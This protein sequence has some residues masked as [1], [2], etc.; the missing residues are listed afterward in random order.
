M[1]HEYLTQLLR[2]QDLS[3]AQLRELREQRDLVERC[4]R[5]SYGSDPR[6]YYA[7]SY[8]KDTM[9]AAA[10]DLDVVV[11]FPPS[12]RRTLAELFWGVNRRLTDCGF[13]VVPRTV[14]LRLPYSGPFHVDVV[15]GKAQDQT[16]RYA[17]L[18]RNVMPPSSL[19]TSLKVHIE[20][21]KDAGL[22]DLVRLMKLWKLR[23]GVSLST[24]A[25]E[26]AVGRAMYGQ[27]RADHAASMMTVFRWM[28]D[29][30]VDARLQDPAN[31]NNIVDVPMSERLNAAWAAR[32]AIDA[33]SWSQ[34][35]W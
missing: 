35:V 19:Q 22:S 5:G 8:G 10:Y 6:F 15:P 4:L 23:H 2:R 11:Y 18:F 31:T 30:L 17:T 16:F 12:E 3:D 24:F 32:R 26:I 20:V 21:V 29:N 27:R 25:T 7:G 14:A 9:I 34:V 1:S 13:V 28:A 33:P